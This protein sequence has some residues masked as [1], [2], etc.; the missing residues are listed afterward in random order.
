MIFNKSYNRDTIFN[1]IT[2]VDFS[3]FLF[4]GFKIPSFGDKNGILRTD[5]NQNKQLHLQDEHFFPK[6][7][8]NNR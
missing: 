5:K 2:Q 6:S 7:N 1:I 3:D 4:I 8:Y